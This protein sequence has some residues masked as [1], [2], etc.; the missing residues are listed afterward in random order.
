MMWSSPKIV[1]G[2]MVGVSILL[3]GCGHSQKD[4][5]PAWVMGASEQFPS[6][7]FL[8]GVGEADSR[9]VAED[10]AYAAIAKIFQANV[11]SQADDTELYRVLEREGRTTNERTLSLRQS[12]TVTTNKVLESATILD[13]WDHPARNSHSV[14]VGID[15]QQAEAGLREKIRVLDGTVDE[16]LSAAHEVSQPLE[17]VGHF[18]LALDALRE[19]EQLNGDLRIIRESGEG[20]PASYQRSRISREFRDLVE[21]HLLVQVDVRGDHAQAMR[22]AIIAG[23]RKRGLPVLQEDSTL[24]VRQNGA[25]V[26]APRNANLIIQGHVHLWP[27]DVPDPLFT[28]VRWC[29]GFVIVDRATQRIVGVAGQTGREGHVTEKE[30][31]ARASSAMQATLTREVSAALA[32]AILNGG[33]E[34]PQPAAQACPN[35]RS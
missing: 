16:E 12:T 32:Q 13:R 33:V 22:T 11:Q 8:L 26:Q 29:G 6:Q 21:R 19:R 20:I 15:R 17:K 3:G 1:L 14:L 7:R 23:L 27:I 28:Y 35:E 18:T 4:A 31:I 5:M 30:A 9:Q 25:E 24:G 10:R 2:A 34:V